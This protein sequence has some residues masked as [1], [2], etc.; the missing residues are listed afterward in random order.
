MSI[1]SSETSPATLYL[2]HNIWGQEIIAVK[3][4]KE[5][6]GCVGWSRVEFIERL[7]EITSGNFQL[8][9]WSATG[10]CLRSPDSLNQFPK[11]SWM[12]EESHPN[13]VA[14]WT[15]QNKRLLKTSKK[16]HLDSYG[17]P[18]ALQGPLHVNQS[19]PRVHT[20]ASH[21]DASTSIRSQGRHRAGGRELSSLAG[22]RP[23]DK[24][25]KYNTCTFHFPQLQKWHICLLQALWKLKVAESSEAFRW[26]AG[27][28]VAAF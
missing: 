27:G 6:K 2:W 24:V 14:F 19:A 26:E 18:G 21:Q 17:T 4:G 16:L 7:V 10:L 23:L 15:L 22:W 28:R 5:Q 9:S 3:G 1:T 25:L 20:T 11:Q 8:T 13:Q 12:Q